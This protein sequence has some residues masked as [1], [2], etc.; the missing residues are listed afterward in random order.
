MPPSDTSSPPAVIPARRRLEAF[1]LAPAPLLVEDPGACCRKSHLRTTDH[2]T[3]LLYPAWPSLLSMTSQTRGL[4]F[5]KDV[6][7]HIDVLLLVHS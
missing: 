4:P 6:S 7:V 3:V 1:L 5:L 2:G